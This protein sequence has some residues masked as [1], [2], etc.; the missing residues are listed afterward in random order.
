MRQ[1]NALKVSPKIESVCPGQIKVI[2]IGGGL[3]TTYVEVGLIYTGEKF[4][5]EEAYNKF[6]IENDLLLSHPLNDKWARLPTII[7]IS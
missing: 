1:L 4:L 5:V 6:R 3:S 7:K 2:D